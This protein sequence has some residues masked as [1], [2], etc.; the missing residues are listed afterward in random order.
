MGK[1]RTATIRR[2]PEGVSRRSVRPFS[3]PILAGIKP[4][5]ISLILLKDQ[6]VSYVR[7]LLESVPQSAAGLVGELFPQALKSLRLKHTSPCTELASELRWLTAIFLRHKERLEQWVSLRTDFERSMVSGDYPKARVQLSEAELRFGKS[8]WA[9]ESELLLAECS[10]GIEG[11]RIA[12]HRITSEAPNWIA[13]LAT[14]LSER[15]E[16]ALAPVEYEAVVQSHL[17]FNDDYHP[18]A[19]SAFFRVSP[20]KRNSIANLEDVLNVEESHSLCDRLIVSTRVLENLIFRESSDLEPGLSDAIQSLADSIICPRFL[21]LK[22]ALRTRTQHDATSLEQKIFQAIHYYTL[23]DYENARSFAEQAIVDSPE[24]LEPYEIFVKSSLRLGRPPVCP[25]SQDSIAAKICSNLSIVFSR[26]D[27][28]NSALET[29][30]RLGYQLDGF[31][32][33][34][35]L[36]AFYALH[37]YESNPH[38]LSRECAIYSSA[39]TPRVV[40][41]LY[42]D[43]PTAYSEL[44]SLE[45]LHPSNAAVSLFKANQIAIRSSTTQLQI[46]LNI[47]KKRLLR[48]EANVCEQLRLYD[49]ATHKYDEV[50]RE[51]DS[52]LGEKSEAASGLYRCLTAKN[53]FSKAARLIVET[54]LER[55][56]IIGKS[57]LIE[58]LTQYPEGGDDEVS[59]D[60]AWPILHFLSQQLEYEERSP[61]RLHD[62]FE[63]FLIA[64]SC[65]KPSELL[66]I[67]SQFNNREFSFFL[68]NVCAFEVLAESF[69]FESQDEIAL[70]RISLCEWLIE[71]DPENRRI[72]QAEIAEISRILAIRELTHHAERSRIFVDTDAII[73]SLPKTILDRATRCMTLGMLKDVSLRQTIEITKALMEEIDNSRIFIIDEGFRL[74]KQV[75]EDLK[76]QFLS[77]NKYGLDANLSQRIRHGTLA[78]ALRA[79]FESQQLVTLKDSSGSYMQ[80]DF[81]I[82]RVCRSEHD[83]IGLSEAL[84]EF[85][86]TVDGI[87]YRVRNEW[88]QIRQ[89]SG[90]SSALF[91]FEFTEDQLVCL[92]EATLSAESPADMVRKVFE[93][94]WQRTDE[95]L[96]EVRATIENALSSEL[97]EAI[98][99]CEQRIDSVI[100]HDQSMPIR[101]AF[102]TCGTHLTMALKA[103]SEWFRLDEQ[104]HVPDCQLRSLLE[105]STEAAKQFCGPSRLEINVIL[106]NDVTVPGNQ[107]RALWDMLFILLDN[108][109][110]HSES[111]QT[112]VTIE[113]V[114][115]GP[116]IK[117][118]CKNELP[119]NIDVE[120]LKEKAARLNQMTADEHS[121]ATSRVEGGSGYG[122]L[123]KILCYEMGLDNYRVFVS[124]DSNEFQ[125]VIELEVPWRRQ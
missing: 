60:I 94:L 23:G 22:K 69:W 57:T 74:F 108:A 44:E 98:K 53:E 5:T 117:M 66:K 80:N 4:D 17:D 59:S 18:I 115:N 123:H 86:A 8:I 3:A 29:L 25:F 67:S 14:F 88:V 41:S 91:N 93:A 28:I 21:F 105:A 71:N 110:K 9:I 32:I 112:N 124:A 83:S 6:P 48:N 87:I 38:V 1:S 97:F 92:Y 111:T 19:R 31:A 45:Q 72:D 76:T 122:K 42:K 63:D 99:R 56:Q 12:L 50:L 13:V 39:F 96:K 90:S 26:E 49:A 82:R 103:I 24:T 95:A 81:W 116:V 84:A 27:K 65:K 120:L 75:F 58:L 70:E 125:A 114:A 47:P 106:D 77:S 16:T 100:G 30:L 119:S 15:V 51:R 7:H 40:V 109:A 104:K 121:L 118:V 35:Q 78:G 64:C 79:P 62:V 61:S 107:F 36:R 34:P 20:A 46:D 10:E 102:T 2:V 37:S 11:N 33:G 55:P 52:T 113:V 54:S 68:R 85:S 43:S 101:A 73:E 89:S